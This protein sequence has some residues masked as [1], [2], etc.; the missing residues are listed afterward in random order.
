MIVAS[1]DEND[2]FFKHLDLSDTET[3]LVLLRQIR[4]DQTASKAE[5]MNAINGIARLT[6]GGPDAASGPG[7]MT[8]AEIHAELDRLKLLTAQQTA[9]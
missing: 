2:R 5:R 3:A 1:D 8:R 6:S 7:G 4:D 9:R